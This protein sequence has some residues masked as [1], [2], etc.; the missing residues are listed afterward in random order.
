[1]AY[2][3]KQVSNP[4]N[5]QSILFLQTAKDSAGKILEMEA[6]WQPHSQKPPD[7]YHPFQEEQ[8]EVITGELTI[9]IDGQIILL[10]AGDWIQIGKNI[11]H[12]MWND[13]N[14]VTVVNWKVFPA[15]NTEHLL[16]LGMGLANDGKINKKGMP[17]ILQ[18]AVMANRFGDVFR[19][20]KPP[21]VI[22]KIFFTILSPFAWLAGFKASYKKYI[23]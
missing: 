12:A 21:F 23:D 18:I 19:L 10:K 5:G 4:V 8:F 14:N 13:S 11:P 20:S 16:E 6:S 2:R 7:H 15:M 3:N 9:K 1:M 17:H 22:Q